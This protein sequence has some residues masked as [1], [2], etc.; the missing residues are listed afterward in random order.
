MHF[1]SLAVAALAATATAQAPGGS[2]QVPIVSQLVADL[3]G[4]LGTVGTALS[5]A[6]G[7]TAGV[8]NNPLGL[9]GSLPGIV[10]SLT[11]VTNLLK[12]VNSLIPLF[13]DADGE[14]TSPEETQ[15]CDALRDVKAKQAN[16]TTAV[17]GV[18]KKSIIG[19][20][21][22]GPILETVINLVTGLL[23]G[24]LGG[25]GG[26]GGAPDIGIPGVDCDLTINPGVGGG[27]A[28]AGANV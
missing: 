22:L 1:K 27:A 4:Q 11:T 26:S 16:L 8:G 28:G 23:G 20:L 25:G 10:T 2:L 12:G 9:A 21:V 17:N 24:I 14:I 6:T 19:G 7:L 5:T 18:K 13:D 15:I 3:L